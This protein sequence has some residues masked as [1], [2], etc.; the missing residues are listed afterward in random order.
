MDQA[1][2]KSSGPRWIAV[3]SASAPVE[4]EITTTTLSINHIGE[5]DRF[6]YFREAYCQGTSGVRG[7][8]ARGD[9]RSLLCARNRVDHSLGAPGAIENRPLPN[10]ARVARDQPA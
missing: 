6:A 9:K 3:Q 7:E 5:A 1:T 4:A 10:V 2:E 8:L